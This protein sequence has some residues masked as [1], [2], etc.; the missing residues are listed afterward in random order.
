MANSDAGGELYSGQ[1]TDMQ[2]QLGASLWHGGLG[3]ASGIGGSGLSSFAQSS[4]EPPKPKAKAKP[5]S[6]A[7]PID[8]NPSMISSPFTSFGQQILHGSA[9]QLQVEAWDRNLV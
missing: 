2:R 8:Q 6:D 9:N 5:K 7:L 4:I 1:M 3:A